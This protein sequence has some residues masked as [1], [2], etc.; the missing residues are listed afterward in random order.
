[1]FDTRESALLTGGG[2]LFWLA[3]VAWIRL[4]PAFVVDP[5]WSDAAFVAS[6]PV[7]SLCVR[8]CRQQVRLAG[9]QLVAG[10]ALLVA[11]ASLLHA[12]ALRWAPGVYGD[13]HAGRLGSAWL[14]WIYGL[15]LALAVRAARP[16]PAP[17]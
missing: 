5:L 17:A 7:A 9:L 6:I 1:M 14:L 3:D 10:V 15:I 11:V 8:A 16:R 2:I 12:L 4:A 13:D